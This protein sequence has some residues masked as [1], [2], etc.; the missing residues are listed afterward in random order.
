MLRRLGLIICRYIC[1][2]AAVLHL[3]PHRLEV[4]TLGS[5]PSNRGSIPLGATK[6]DTQAI[7]SN[8]FRTMNIDST[9]IIYF[10]GPSGGGK[11]SAAKYISEVQTNIVWQDLDKETTPDHWATCEQKILELE[12]RY[13]SD[14]NHLLLDIGAGTQNLPEFADFLKQN[15]RFNSTIVIIPSPEEG[16]ARNRQY[17]WPDR[18]AVEYHQTEYINRKKLYSSA[19]YLADVSG[20]SRIESAQ[21]VENLVKSLIDDDAKENKKLLTIW[22]AT[23]DDKHYE[24]YRKVADRKDLRDWVDRAYIKDALEDFLD[25]GFLNELRNNDFYGRLW[26]LEVAE[27]LSLTGLKMIPTNGL[28]PD[29]CLELNSG[30]KIWVEVV[31]P[32]PDETLDQLERDA[33]SSSGETYDVPGKEIAL[34]YSSSLVQKARKFNKKYHDCINPSDYI[35]IAVSAFP[36]N[37]MS[38]DINLF[39]PSVLPIEHQVVY[40]SKDSSPLDKNIPRPTH[41]IKTEWEGKPGGLPIK[42]TFLYPGDDFPYID[43]VVFSEASNLQQLLGVWSSAFNDSTNIPHVFQNYSGKKL[44]EEFT[45][46]FYYHPFEDNGELVSSAV[47]DPHL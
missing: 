32:R 39:L 1:E 30:S 21:I 14:H 9:M 40:F 8:S 10:I 23:G 26:E 24:H 37:S 16:L 5:H 35:L 38:S 22:S 47:I 28:G 4:R 17:V 45:K 7:G 13:S 33:F 18:D 36:P 27:W 3:R 42:K 19:S 43:G 46:K 25:K 34:R 41:T 31:L 11:T 6:L 15:N 20:K 2:A 12:Q 29:F 44:P